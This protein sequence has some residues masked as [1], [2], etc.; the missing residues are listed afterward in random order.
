MA[1]FGILEY[2]LST[3][4]LSYIYTHVC[5]H[6][7]MHMHIQVVTLYASTFYYILMIK[8]K[9]KNNF[10][11]DIFP[12]FSETQPPRLIHLCWHQIDQVLQKEVFRVK[13]SPCVKPHMAIVTRSANEKTAADGML[14]ADARELCL[15]S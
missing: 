12:L 9:E 8:A 6:V 2:I 5:R 7:G 3:L 10:I 15:L 14:Q 1:H 11:Y 4:H 13:I